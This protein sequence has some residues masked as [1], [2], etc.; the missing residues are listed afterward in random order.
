MSSMARFDI[1]RTAGLATECRGKWFRTS[2][3]D[4]W[5]STDQNSAGMLQKLPEAEVDPFIELTMLKAYVQHQLARH[6]A[7]S[8]ANHQAACRQSLAATPVELN[9]CYAAYEPAK[10]VGH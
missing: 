10:E 1:L 7:P 9:F 4:V 8:H 5:A 6:P 3:H 2:I